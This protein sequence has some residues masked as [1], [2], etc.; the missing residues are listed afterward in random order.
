MVRHRVRSAALFLL[1]ALP[2]LG[3][4]NRWTISGPESAGA[5]KQ[6]VFDPGDSSIVYCATLNGLFRS[7]DHGVHWS[8]VAELFPTTVFNVAVAQANP[9]RVY[10]ATVLG[11]YRSDDRGVTWR[12]VNSA[13]TVFVAVSPQNSNVVY[14]LALGGAVRSDDGGMTFGP[15][16]SEAPTN[17]NVVVIDPQS[18]D[19][20][21]AGSLANGGIWKTT[22]GGA[23]WTFGI[24]N[25]FNA[26]QVYW[27]AIDPS[28]GSTLYAGV[29]FDGIYK[30]TNGGAA[31]TKLPTD[32]P[33]AS[34]F[35]LAVDPRSPET[36]L[37]GTGRGALKSADGGATWTRLELPGGA[38]DTVGAVAVDPLSS[39]N[40]LV[41]PS[42]NV[43]RS[44]DGGATFT[45]ATSGIL[46]FAADAIVADRHDESIVYAAG[47][48]G[49]YKSTDHGRSWS[50]STTVRPRYLALDADSSILYA[51]A[52]DTVQR[53]T[54]GGATWTAFNAGLPSGVLLS[55]RRP[56]FLVADPQLAGTL[57]TI[58]GG[59]AYKK[60]G[61]DPWI[62]RG[63]GSSGTISFLTID[64]HDSSTL[65]AT[66]SAGLSKSTNGGESWSSANANLNLGSAIL[67]IGL[68]VDPFDSRH[69]FTW[70]MVAD[71]QSTDGGASWLPFTPPFN[72]SAIV[73]DAAHPGVIYANTTGTLHRSTD[74]GK[75]WGSLQSAGLYLHFLFAV[76][77]RGTTLYAGGPSGGVFVYQF[78]RGRAVR[79]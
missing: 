21:Y 76:G 27:L 22:D 53:S 5:A 35:S 45:D 62:A 19:T 32:F 54:D 63:S 55:L 66:G 79:H 50:V 28:N 44:T 49:F 60:V 52:A 16:G 34:G 26:R 68:S 72:G 8:A 47:F 56:V 10:A 30:T 1:F 4:F 57:Y 37:A 29:Q 78:A 13:A 75:T 40:V 69:L 59:S 46:S 73:F 71:Y 67:P 48:S 51:V 33:N 77:P 9:S 23:H 64:P 17:S 43:L 42:G 3:G 6:I 20:A 24:N 41:N 14:S 58:V 31:W 61:D 11:I 65:Y 38:D 18:P 15:K 74:G 7:T 39:A 36:L 70:S 12:I 2:A 25:G